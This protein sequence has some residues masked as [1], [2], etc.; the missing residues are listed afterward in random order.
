ML[1]DEFYF[2]NPNK[3]L[4]AVYVQPCVI[5]DGKQSVGEG[6]RLHGFLTVGAIASHSR[7]AYSSAVT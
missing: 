6:R 3:P 4:V 1:G 7:D 2:G 5:H